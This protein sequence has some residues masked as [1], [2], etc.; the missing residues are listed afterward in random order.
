MPV[1]NPDTRL[2]LWLLSYYRSDSTSMLCFTLSAVCPTNSLF[3][4]PMLASVDTLSP[5]SVHF[6]LRT[7]AVFIKTA[8]SSSQ[9]YYS[10][11]THTEHP[12]THTEHCSASLFWFLSRFHVMSEFFFATSRSDMLIRDRNLHT[13]FSSS[14]IYK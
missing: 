7:T 1:H 6:Y 9:D 12:F 11:C 14:L 3:P 8:L 4:N 10:Q 5:R 2:P 13:F